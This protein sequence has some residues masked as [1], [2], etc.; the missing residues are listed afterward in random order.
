D[1]GRND[2]LHTTPGR[3]TIGQRRS[4]ISRRRR[5]MGPSVEQRAELVD[6]PLQRPV[7]PRQQHYVQEQKNP[8]GRIGRK[9]VSQVVHFSDLR[10]HPEAPSTCWRR[11]STAS[12]KR[13]L[14]VRNQSSQ[15]N[16]S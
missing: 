12:S 7:S 6:L 5:L 13:A 4:S 14:S 3:R 9:Q 8:D 10:P 15:R 16:S 2:S 11:S 1:M